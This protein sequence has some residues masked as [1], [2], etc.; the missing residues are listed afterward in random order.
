MTGLDA[1]GLRAWLSR[2]DNPARKLPYTLELVEADG[3][4]VGI[5]TGRPNAIVAEA[6]AAGTIPELAGHPGRRREVRYGAGSRVDLLLDCR[7]EEHT[8]EFPSLM[9]ISDAVFCL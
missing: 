8:S 2:S 7:S 6:I 5:P 9:R 4:L 1:P 3:D